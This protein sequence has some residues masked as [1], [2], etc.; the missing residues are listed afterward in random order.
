MEVEVKAVAVKSIA[1]E[2]AEVLMEHL[3]LMESTGPR[4]NTRD[5]ALLDG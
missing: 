5:E 4:E 1:L 2:V 3:S